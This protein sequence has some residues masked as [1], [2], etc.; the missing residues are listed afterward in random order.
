[1]KQDDYLMNSIFFKLLSSEKVLSGFK[2]L[3]E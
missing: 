3:E 1:M 2:Y